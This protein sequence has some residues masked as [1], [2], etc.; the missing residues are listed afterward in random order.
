MSEYVYFNN[1]VIKSWAEA[2]DNLSNCRE[3]RDPSR[4]SF[5]RA[6]ASEAVAA[7]P[8]VQSIKVDCFLFRSIALL[9][10]SFSQYKHWGS[11]EAI[12]C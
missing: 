3:F 6:K 5:F 9:N 7:A 4:D 8:R 12:I 10:S 11:C 2:R 1:P